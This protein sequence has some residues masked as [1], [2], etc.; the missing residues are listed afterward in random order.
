MTSA[1]QKIEYMPVEFADEK[2]L[3]LKQT[4]CKGATDNELKLFMHVCVKTG[5]DPF[6]RQIYSI[7]RGGQRTIQTSIDGFRLIAE[8]SKKYSPGR[9]PSFAYNAEG[10]MLSATSYIKKMTEDGTW[11]EVSATAYL[12]EYNPGNNTFWKKMPHV[13]LAKCAEAAALRRAFPAELSGVYSDDEMLQASKQKSDNDPKEENETMIEPVNMIEA[14]FEEK[15]ASEE[16]V[17]ADA[18]HARKK[19]IM[20]LIDKSDLPDMTKYVEQLKNTYKSKKEHE[21]FLTLD[22]QTFVKN[23]MMWRE[24]Q[25]QKKIA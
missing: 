21:F 2:I 23:F 15:K 24:K 17:L 8:R 19:E 7:A 9:E 12:D 3:L 22:A 20:A 11:H 25:D 1:L 18:L 10:K 6:M 13:M 16:K 5:L 14:E 4:V